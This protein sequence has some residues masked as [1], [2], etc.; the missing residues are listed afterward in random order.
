MGRMDWDG[1]LSGAMLRAH[2]GADKMN[3]LQNVE[4]NLTAKV[5]EKVQID[6]RIT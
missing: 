4:F 6:N 3:N 5:E 1:S 2:Y